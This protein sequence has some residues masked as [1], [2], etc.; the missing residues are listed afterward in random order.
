M[1]CYHVTYSNKRDAKGNIVKRTKVMVPVKNRQDY[2]SIRN[3]AYVKELLKSYRKAKKKDAKLQLPQ[4]VYNVLTNEAGTLAGQHPLS[5]TICM[6]IDHIKRERYPLVLK[7]LMEVIKELGILMI[8]TSAKG[9]E[10][11]DETGAHVVFLRDYTKTPEENLQHAIDVINMEDVTYDANAKDDNRVMFCGDLEYLDNRLFDIV[12]VPRINPN[13]VKA[14][15]ASGATATAPTASTTFPDNYKGIPYSSIIAEFWKRA[16]GEPLIGERNTKI[17]KLAVHLRAICDNNPVWLEQI[18]PDYDLPFEEFSATLRSAC[19]EPPKD[20]TVTMKGIL[21]QLSSKKKEEPVCPKLPEKLPGI[22][23]TGLKQFP[24]EYWP[25]LAAEAVTLLGANAS[26]Y[27]TTYIDNRVIAPNLFFGGVGESGS[28]KSFCQDLFNQM[29]GPTIQKDDALEWQKVYANQQKRS[30]KENA[31]DKPA[32]YIP[33]L[34]ISETMSC[35]S[36]LAN[37][38]AIG[39]NDILLFNFAEAD[40]LFALT[41]KQQ[42]DISVLFRK[43]FDG[44]THRQYYLSDA[45]VSTMC[46]LLCSVILTGTPQAVLTR[47]FLD[48]ENGLL[49]R[50]IVVSLESSKSIKTPVLTPLSQEEQEEFDDLLVGLW[51]RNQEIEG[52]RLLSLPK[53]Q[54]LVSELLDEFDQQYQDGEISDGEAELTHR[55]GQIIMR[56]SLALCALY[57]EETQE[58]LNFVEWLGR[59]SYYQLCKLFAQRVQKDKEEANRLM[60]NPCDK[61]ATSLAVLEVMPQV[62]TKQEFIAERERRGLSTDRDTIKKTLGRWVK[63]GIITKIGKGLYEKVS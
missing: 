38:S 37:M 28:G 34:H 63:R 11:Y 54:K 48:T 33:K 27:R 8:E 52:T 22:I 14:L 42:A 29:T 60:N 61:R 2:E 41:Q 21:L 25:M 26:H 20:I 16:G 58:I 49:R 9:K 36:M 17:H 5:S 57:N 32:K 3:Q 43:G 24:R 35:S 30:S 62:F 4:F 47:L 13:I 51:K 50:F 56:A 1:S 59:F 53:T 39:P 7:R 23:A 12:E 18:I 44:D 6:D 46:T 31:K 45:S 15:P 19:N 10:D 55:I 40:G